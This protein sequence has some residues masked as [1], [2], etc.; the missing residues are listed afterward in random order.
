MTLAAC[1]AGFGDGQLSNANKTNDQLARRLAR[2]EQTQAQ[3]LAKW[4]ELEPSIQRLAQIE[5]DIEDLVAQ[6]SA[7]AD[8]GYDLEG[9]PPE[10]RPQLQPRSSFGNPFDDTEISNDG[11]SA[12]STPASPNDLSI[13]SALNSTNNQNG[14]ATPPATDQGQEQT[15]NDVP[16]IPN[17]TAPINQQD[18]SVGAALPEISQ[19]N[20]LPQITGRTNTS[21]SNDQVFGNN[22]PLSAAETLNQENATAN[23]NPTGEEWGLHVGTFKDLSSAKELLNSIALQTS[24]SNLTAI[25]KAVTLST[26]R[27]INRLIIGSMKLEDT[28]KACEQIRLVTGYCRAIRF[29]GVP[30][31]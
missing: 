23:I 10:E 3:H 31:K 18:L 12:F 11:T 1:A 26:G 14:I 30:L 25:Q 8:V 9:I 21:N 15:S 13:S 28:T 20:D 16:F 19:S 17:S 2:V 22:I 24:Y 6:L 29:D 4:H 7:L 27:T 5:G